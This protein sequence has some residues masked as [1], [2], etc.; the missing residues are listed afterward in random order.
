MNTPRSKPPERYEGPKFGKVLGTL[1]AGIH[2]NELL[3]A[4]GFIGTYWPHTEELM[5]AFFGELLGIEDESSARQVFRSIVNQRVRIT[6]MKTMLEKSPAHQSKTAVF[7]E[8]IA[9]YS[10]L[11]SARN[12]YLH[13]LW[14]TANDNRVYLEEATDDYDR[15]LDSRE[16]KVREVEALIKRV[17]VFNK[18]LLERAETRTLARALSSPQ[19]P[20][21]PK[22]D[23]T[24]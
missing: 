22:S 8:I 23:S 11:N 17:G 7:D 12:T 18:R 6:I 14:Y 21:S 13:G 4:V 15:F 3:F 24:P 5:S 1:K 16:V 19:K 10:S 2:N 20:P 9:E